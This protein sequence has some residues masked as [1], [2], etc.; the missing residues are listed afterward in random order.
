MKLFVIDTEINEKTS[1]VLLDLESGLAMRVAH[2]INNVVVGDFA[3]CG[4]IW[5]KSPHFVRYVKKATVRP[6]NSKV[7]LRLHLSPTRIKDVRFPPIKV[8]STHE[9]YEDIKN[10][11]NI[12]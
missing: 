3:E 12:S 10:E 8:I 1:S 4:V 7:A 2:E 11:Q 9:E 6:Y 5:K